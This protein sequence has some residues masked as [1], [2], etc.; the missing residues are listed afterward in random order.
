MDQAVLQLISEIGA[1]LGQRSRPSKDFIV[2][3]LRQ[4]VSALSQLEQFSL[5]ESAN[6]AQANNKQKEALRKQ[7]AA[8]NR[9]ASLKTLEHV[10]ICDL[11]QHADKDVRL[12]VAICVTEIFR[13]RAPEPPFEDKDLKGVFKLIISTFADLADTSSPLFSKRVKI[14]ETVAR[15][16]CCV[17]MLDIDSEALIVEMFKIFFSVARDDHHASLRD[18]MSSIMIDILNVGASQQLLEVILQNLVKG[19]KDATCA[20]SQLAALV[21]SCAD[22]KELKPLVCWFLTSCINDRDAVSSGLKEFYHEII[23]KIF[24]CAPEML[25]AVIPSLIRE[26]LADQVDVRIQAVNLVGKLFALPEHHAAQKYHDLFVEF[27]K[28]FSDKSVDVRISALHCAKA[29]YVA[30]P[31]GREFHEIISAVE[32]RLLDFDDR[33]RMQAILVACDL[34][35]S[36]LQLVPSKLISQ[37]TERIRDKKISVRKMALQKLMEVYQDYCRKCCEGSMT[38]SDHFEEIPCKILMLY[39]DKDCKEFSSHSMELVLADDLFPEHLS[40]EERANHWIHIFSLFSPLHEKALHT[41]LSQ[42][43]RL[44]SEIKNYLALRKQL[45]E[46]WSEDLQKTIENIF[47]KMAS[48]FPD[49]PKAEEWLHKVNQ[50]KDNNIFNSLEQMLEEQTFATRKIIQDML[51][52]MVAE[53]N[54]YFEFLRSLFSKCSYNI[55]SSEHVHYILDYISNSTVGNRRFEDSSVKLLLAIVRTFPAI[56]KDSEEQFQKLVEQKSA[57]NDKLIEVLAKAGSHIS[58][59]LSDIYPFL[60]K[61]CLEG[62]RTQAKFAI[63]A[64]AALSSDQSFFSDLYQ[65]LI[66]SLYSQ[67]NLPTVL[68]SLGCIAQYSISTFDTRDAEITKYISHKIIQAEHLDDVHNA[69]SSDGSFGCSDPSQL[70]VYGLKTLV[71]SYLPEQGNCV[72]RDFIGLLD[73]L[74]R[75]LQHSDRYVGS[76]SSESDGACIRLVA[77]KSILRLSRRWDHHISPEIFRFT[78][79]NAKDSSSSIRRS[80][81]NKIHKMFKERKL[82][83]R[84]ACAFPLAMMDGIEDLQCHSSKF[85]AEFIKDYSIVAR[86]R[87]LSSVQGAVF[88]YPAYV[89]VFLIHVLSRDTGFP[90]EGCQDEQ[91]CADLCSPLYIFMQAL[92]NSSIVDGDQD[93]VNDAVLYLFSILRAIRKAEDA[94]NVQMTPKLHMLADIGIFILNALK[95]GEISASQAPGQ[96]LLPSSLYKMSFAK[97]NANPRKT[98]FDESFLSCVLQKLRSYVPQACV[99]KP[100]RTLKYSRKCQEDVPKCNLNTHITSNLASNEPDDLLWREKTHVRTVR[101]NIPPGKRGGN[102]VS[103]INPGPVGLHECSTIHW[104]KNIASE[105]FERTLEGNRLSSCGSVSSLVE[106][107]VSTRK[108]KRTAASFLENAVRSGKYTGQPS[109]RPRTNLNDS[110]GTKEDVLADCSNQCHLWHCDPGKHSRRV[111]IKK[112]NATTGGRVTNEGT[113]L[114]HENANEN[115]RGKSTGTSE[116]EVVNTNEKAVSPSVSRSRQ[117]R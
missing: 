114:N 86:T 16:K 101:S 30:N 91:L 14:L 74:L 47:T 113:S 29:I 23:F 65:E 37:V 108:S 49:P 79:L 85:L 106:S 69:T 63:L 9:V 115:R 70:K 82:P 98:Y 58:I 97:N 20:A 61:M 90:S 68:Q 7:E 18:A 107:R 2:K 110:R 99:Q 53:S 89:V 116:S 102:V 75:M 33:V 73:I 32:D 11:L 84:Y 42:K 93:L 57:V 31:S 105:P 100:L 39:F 10:I 54:P 111:R 117:K 94:V 71:K 76:N 28:R 112:A 15:L 67:R 22:E 35:K 56:L 8:Q 36:N 78:I 59:K 41:I 24:Q 92:V 51:L 66:I 13:I 96:I 109:K 46:N 81:L 43:R 19:R 55:F 26:L 83:I 87:Q 64:M 27:L 17:I 103:S 34:S 40:V 4:A 45:K 25:L 95:H 6:E 44:Q 88:G 72:R 12:L 62:T 38:T 50:L 21:I 77:A 80:F 3:S 104:Q 52:R 1:R 5:I 60:Q 48:F